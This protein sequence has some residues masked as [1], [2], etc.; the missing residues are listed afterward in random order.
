VAILM[1]LEPQR[2]V[3]DTYVVHGGHASASDRNPGNEARPLKTIHRAAQLAQPGDTV[4]VHAGI[5]RERVAPA[6]GGTKERPIVYMAAPDENVVIK[7]SDVWQPDWRKKSDQ[8]SIYAGALDSKMFGETGENPYQTRLRGMPANQQLTLGQVFVDGQPLREVDNPK[9]LI[10][11]PGSWSVD[12]GG[13]DLSIHFPPGKPPAK[14]LVEIATRQRIFAPHRRGLGYLHVRGFTMEHCANQFPEKFWQSDSPQAGALGC[15][16]GHH[17]LIEDNTVRF[18]KSIGIDCGYE[19]RHDLEGAQPTPQNTGYHVIRNNRVTDNGCCGIAG[20]SSLETQIVDNVIERNNWNHHTAP[21]IG[22][23]KVHNFIKGRI[24]GNLVRDNDA[25]GIWLD[26]GYR[27]A[28]VC[29]NLVV[30]NRGSAVFIELGQGPVLIDNNVLANTRPSFDV[31]DPRADGLYTHDASGVLFVH[32]LV[33]G[34]QGFGS[35]HRKKTNRPRAGVSN[36]VL[37]NNIFIDNQAGQINL[38]YPGPESRNNQ[39]DH[40][41]FSPRGEFLINPWGGTPTAELV[42]LV[43]KSTGVRPK[44]WNQTSPQMSLAEWQKLNGWDSDNIEA[45]SATVSL[46]PDLLLTLDLGRAL[47]QLKTAPLTGAQRDFFGDPLPAK[48]ALAGPFQRLTNDK[49]RFLL[50]PPAKRQ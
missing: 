17:W 16:A 18:A 5:Y 35:F 29:R 34:C 27:D 39:V 42:D 8:Y 20:M 49:N 7:G 28:R 41:L 26:N 12:N 4:L 30:G 22:G 3:A 32:N 9:D 33:F 45:H 48:G 10:A 23:I 2:S 25:Y 46:S 31:R 37:Q 44:L 36:I 47:R 15:R 43:E 38:P 1:M 24:E 21:E 6:R 13:R 11:T 50:W 19:G 40:N 14:R